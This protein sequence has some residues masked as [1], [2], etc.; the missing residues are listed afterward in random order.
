MNKL[1]KLV[2]NLRGVNIPE[3]ITDILRERSILDEIVRIIK[4]RLYLEGVDSLGNKFRTDSAKRQ[5]NAAYAGFTY[6]QKKQKGQRAINVTFR[7]TGQF[8]GSIK[9]QVPYKSVNITGDFDKD[10]GHIY[11]NFRNSYTGEKEFEN[12]VLGL[13]IGQLDYVAWQLVYP[14]LMKYLNNLISGVQL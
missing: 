10:F 4:D 11:D 12:A 9:A 13:T 5:G 1:E 7:D 8:H 3:I 6:Q 2:N 14:R